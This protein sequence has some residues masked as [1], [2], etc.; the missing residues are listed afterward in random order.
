MNLQE[1]KIPVAVLIISIILIF[2]SLLTKGSDIRLQ[3]AYG[4]LDNV[5]LKFQTVDF[6]L[7]EAEFITSLFF[8]FF[9]VG[10]GFYLLLF[11][12][13]E[14]LTGVF[15]RLPRNLQFFKIEEKKLRWFQIISSNYSSVKGRVRR[16]RKR[17][18]TETVDGTGAN[19]DSTAQKAPVSNDIETP[20]QNFLRSC[21]LLCLFWTIYVSITTGFY[22]AFFMPLA[23]YY[24]MTL[25]ANS[26]KEAISKS[27]LY[28]LGFFVFFVFAGALVEKNR[29]QYNMSFD[30]FLGGEF[31]EALLPLILCSAMTFVTLRRKMR[32]SEDIEFRVNWL[33]LSGVLVCVL[34]GSGIL[35]TQHKIESFDFSSLSNTTNED[36]DLFPYIG[37]NIQEEEVI[38]LISKWGGK[39]VIRISD[40]TTFYDFFKEGVGFNLND[41]ENIH[42]IFLYSGSKDGKHDRFTG[43]L[44]YDLGFSDSRF[45]VEKKLGKAEDIDGQ[46]FWWWSKRINVG[47][48]E[49]KVEQ[50]V[51]F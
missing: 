12:K 18:T 31:A 11:S 46:D 21:I 22:L 33:Y 44:P 51:L 42:M 32:N 13:D 38:D 25:K 28:P 47:F 27:I 16:K 7:F 26:L 9:L 48:K 23:Y 36:L 39:P 10:L 45:E 3:V 14:K 29:Y 20:R 37:R 15:R 24:Y 2:Y 43:E 50:I 19:I 1:K 49:G 4:S 8:L 40:G 6:M 35:F 17:R 30:Y 5:P 34:I 41:E